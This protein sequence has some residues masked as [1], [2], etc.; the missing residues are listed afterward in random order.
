M[1]LVGILLWWF[2]VRVGLVCGFVG[3]FGCDCVFWVFC[4]CCVDVIWWFLGLVIGVGWFFCWIGFVWLGRLFCVCVLL[5]FFWVYFGVCVCFVWVRCW[6]GCEW[7]FVVLVGVWWIWVVGV[8]GECCC[9]FRWRGCVF[10]FVWYWL[11]ICWVG[12]WFVFGSLGVDSWVLLGYLGVGVVGYVNWVVRC[13]VIEW[14][15]VV[16]CWNV[17]VFV[18]GV[19][20]LYLV[21]SWLGWRL[22]C[23][24]VLLF[25]FSLCFLIVVWCVLGGWGCCFGGLGWF[26]WLWFG[27]RSVMIDCVRLGFVLLLGWLVFFLVV[28]V[29]VGCVLG[30]F[31][32]GY[33]N[34]LDWLYLYV[35]VFSL[36]V[37]LVCLVWFCSRWLGFWWWLVVLVCFWIFW[38]VVG[39]VGGV[40]WWVVVFVLFG[41][42]WVWGLFWCWLVVCLGSVFWGN[43]CVVVLVL[44]GVVFGCFG[45]GLFGLVW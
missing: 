34:W 12:C 16:F 10:F 32:F 42:V 21:I 24:S 2:M 28:L 20:G 31:V 45:Y 44:V 35:W 6:V 9:F 39:C 11:G 22:C 3:L 25:C 27:W 23:G 4:R 5:G 26:F 30:R 40:V 8:I 14:F 36:G 43:D 1:V 41:F 18:I 7:R 15:C 19:C 37:F 38:I 17:F 33:R 13:C 29:G